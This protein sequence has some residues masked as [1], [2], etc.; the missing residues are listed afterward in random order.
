M[1]GLGA[2]PRDRDSWSGW[3]AGSPGRG[4][5][6]GR[7]I[8]LLVDGGRRDRD[9]RG[10]KNRDGDRR[11]QDEHRAQEADPDPAR[12]LERAAVNH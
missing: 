7:F 1:L 4:G 12:S 2:S 6:F 3:R 5:G 9:G 11:E 10:G 8:V